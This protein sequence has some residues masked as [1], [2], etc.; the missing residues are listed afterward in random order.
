M[1]LLALPLVGW[2]WQLARGVD[3]EIVAKTWKRELVVERRRLEQQSDW[4]DRLPPDS[5]AVAREDRLDPSGER[6]TAP[7]CRFRAP[8]W[9]LAWVAQQEGQAPRPPRW[10]QPTLIAPG[11]PK[12]PD[13]ERLGGRRA[14]QTVVLRADDGREW[15]CRP[16]PGHWQAL[17]IGQRFYLAVDRFG[18]ADCASLPPQ[19]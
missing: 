4:C 3:V 18:V 17:Q 14:R 6:G 1:L 10:P 5:Q 15:Q 8:T 12:L 7:Y 9:G 19:R 16:E 2:M 11:D 13:G